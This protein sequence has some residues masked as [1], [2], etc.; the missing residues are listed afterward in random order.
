M[1]CP[2]RFHTRCICTP[3]METG[4]LS[5]LQHPLELC[6]YS[7]PSQPPQPLMQDSELAGKEGGLR[8]LWVSNNSFILE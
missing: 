7:I 3:G 4:I 5:E 1:C 8:N 6:I 2:H